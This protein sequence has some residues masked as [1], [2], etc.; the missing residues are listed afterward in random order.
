M[1][2]KRFKPITPGTRQKTVSSFEEVTATKPEKSLLV[3][4]NHSGG[5]NNNGRITVRHI[6]GGNRVKYRLIDFKRNK[7]NI[8]AKVATIEYDPNRTAYIALLHYVDGEKRY[9]LAP[10]GLNVGDTVVSGETADIKAG[11]AL[12]LS[13]IPVG[14]LVHN[15]ELQPGNGGVLVRTAGAS[16]QLMAKE[17]KYATLKMPS[18]EMRLILLTCK[19]T[20]GQ[21]GNLDHEL[22]SLGKAGRK[23]HMGVRP[24]VRGVVMNPNDH[25]H[26]GGEGKSPVGMPSPVTPWGK[27]AL[28]KKT[29]K[30]NKASDRFIVKRIN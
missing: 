11:N 27:P 17:G 16:A 13:A 1:A 19:A 23:R 15:V 29:R 20:I 6:G 5:R 7:D 2:V 8:P 3:T 30:H 14:T 10:V 4:K 26:G 9:I 21:I 24:T 25:P 28:G 18:G 12:P 22:V